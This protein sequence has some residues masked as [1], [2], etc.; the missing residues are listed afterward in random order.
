MSSANDQPQTLSNALATLGSLAGG[1]WG[2]SIGLETEDNF[3]MG[4]LVGAAVGG[5]T[6]KV[7]GVA[8]SMAIRVAIS[9]GSV[10]TIMAWFY[11]RG[12]A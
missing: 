3:F 4:A 9:I 10:L 6:G 2:G 8:V 1:L 7:L 5:V 11:V 12:G